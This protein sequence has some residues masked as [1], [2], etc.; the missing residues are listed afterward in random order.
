MTIGAHTDIFDDEVKA[1]VQIEWRKKEMEYGPLSYWNFHNQLG[2]HTSI[3]LLS[4]TAV[5]FL[6]SVTVIL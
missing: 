3:S 5:N 6:A 4:E 2:P 1:H